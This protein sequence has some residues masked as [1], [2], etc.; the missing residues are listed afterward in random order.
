MTATE[1]ETAA[2]R[3]LLDSGL[4]E[5]LGERDTIENLRYLLTHLDLICFAVET[6]DGV[7][8]RGDVLADNIGQL[9]EDARKTGATLPFG[10]LPK[11]TNAL[12][13]LV[14]SGIFDPKTVAVLAEVGNHASEA[15]ERNEASH[16]P[17][18]GP[19][20][21]LKSMFDPDVQRSIGFLVGMAKQY[22]HMIR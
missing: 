6:V 5:K 7:L 17:P 21:L 15:Y 20:G 14:K 4:L 3:K 19:L 11:L 1:S 10:E 9:I 13:Q 22:G 8:R 18:V 16:P 12:S 2:N